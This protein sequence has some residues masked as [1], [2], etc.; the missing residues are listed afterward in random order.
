MPIL[1]GTSPPSP[2]PIDADTAQR[3]ARQELAHREYHR[4]DPDVVQRAVNW[5]LDRL[6]R[7]GNAAGSPAGVALLL[8]GVVLVVLIVLALRR[9]GPLRRAVRGV[10]SN[11]DPLRSEGLADHRALAQQLADDGQFA[12]AVREWLRAAVQTIE[13][14]G[15][16]DARPGRTGAEVAREAGVRMPAAQTELAEATRAFEEIWFGRRRATTA[17]VAT[18]RA[19][20]DAARTARIVVAA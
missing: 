11:S 9:A 1:H 6:D 13:G 4:D 17:D 8:V 10:A 2:G 18:A 19:A 5:L 16:L 14:R 15:V 20:A 3:L 7:I 12:L